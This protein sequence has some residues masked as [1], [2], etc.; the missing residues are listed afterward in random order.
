MGVLAPVR[1]RERERTQVH[2]PAKSPENS[3]IL[4]ACMTTSL[5]CKIS[6]SKW[7]RGKD[8]QLMGK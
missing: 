2:T 3:E 6:L 4:K 8:E 5:H 1:E 7:G